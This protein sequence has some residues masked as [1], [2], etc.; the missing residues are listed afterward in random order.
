MARLCTPASTPLPPI[1]RTST[2]DAHPSGE[3]TQVGLDS[4]PSSPSKL[5]PQHSALCELST[6]QNPS[7]LAVRL[8]TPDRVPEPSMPTT[9]AGVAL[10]SSLLSPKAP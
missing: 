7:R 1:P 2:G 8:A 6:A 9:V 10:S 3:V 5:S 4:A